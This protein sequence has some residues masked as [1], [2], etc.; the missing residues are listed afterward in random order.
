MFKEIVCFSLTKSM[1]SLREQWSQVTVNSNCWDVQRGTSETVKRLDNDF[2]FPPLG[3]DSPSLQHLSREGGSG[4]AALPP[5]ARPRRQQ[6]ARCFHW[7]KTGRFCLRFRISGPSVLVSPQRRH[8]AWNLPTLGKDSN[9]QTA[10]R[11][12][13]DEPEEVV[14][15]STLSR[16]EGWSLGAVCLS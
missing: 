15:G 5:A 9:Q 7:R 1:K 13:V 6:A 3:S 11:S 2:L 12:V 14:R 16:N 4:R 8:C 10:V